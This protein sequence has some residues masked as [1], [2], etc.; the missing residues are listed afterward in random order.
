MAECEHDWHIGFGDETRL[1]RCVK[2]GMTRTDVAPEEP[3]LLHESGQL[4]PWWPD[5][6]R[7]NLRVLGKL[8]EELGEAG[9]A[10]S[11]CIIQGIEEAEPVTGKVNRVWLEDELADIIATTQ[12]AV[13]H[14]GLDMNR[15][16]ERAAR[17]RLHLLAWAELISGPE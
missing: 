9:A 13:D 15:M 12:V 7:Q 2:C 11:R 1:E 3:K 10:V 17:K 4:N 8:G 16:L 5:T 6:D 14:F